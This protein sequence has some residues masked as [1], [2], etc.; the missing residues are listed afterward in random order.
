MISEISC[1]WS[2]S[3]LFSIDVVKSWILNSTL[4][5][6]CSTAYNLSSLSSTK[7]SAI[8]TLLATRDQSVLIVSVVLLNTNWYADFTIRRSKQNWVL[9]CQKTK[10]LNPLKHE[11]TKIKV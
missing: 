6:N 11:H 3:A 4:S 1:V 9:F 8:I 2:L 10:K 5:T 7:L